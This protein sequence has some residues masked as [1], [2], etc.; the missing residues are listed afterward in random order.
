MKILAAAVALLP[1]L[2][3]GSKEH[4]PTGASPKTES[5]KPPAETASA[6]PNLPVPSPAPTLPAKAPE[7]AP[8]PGVE[9]DM[10]KV[11]H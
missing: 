2:A 1:L 5:A 8:A 11:Q 7:P 9:P 3:C 6:K 4:S 10:I